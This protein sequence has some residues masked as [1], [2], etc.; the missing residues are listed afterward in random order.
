MAETARVDV[1]FLADGRCLVRR[2]AEQSAHAPAGG[3]YRCPLPGEG[4]EAGAIE[5]R[6]ALPSGVDGHD[7][8]PQ[9]AWQQIEGRWIGTA[10]LPAAPAF[11]HV[12]EPSTTATAAPRAAFGWNFYGFFI[13]SALFIAVYFLWAAW[14]AGRDPVRR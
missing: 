10:S 13:F 5:L 2:G 6:V 7:A 4:L 12:S 14:M 1:T 9:L 11:V 3:G 8:F